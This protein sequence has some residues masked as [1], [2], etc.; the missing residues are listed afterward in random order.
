MGGGVDVNSAGSNLFPLLPPKAIL[1]SHRDSE[2]L[3]QF[4]VLTL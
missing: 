2:Q 4:K 3:V 1:S